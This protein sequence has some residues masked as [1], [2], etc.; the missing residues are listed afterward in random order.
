MP[1]SV[2]L[3]SPNGQ[4]CGSGHKSYTLRT[5]KRGQQAA[6]GEVKKKLFTGTVNVN[7]V[8]LREIV[9]IDKELLTMTPSLSF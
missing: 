5:E 1:A 6:L 8:S 7:K 9:L 3:F 2:F 4:T